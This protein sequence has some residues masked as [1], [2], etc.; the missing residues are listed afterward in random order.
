MYPK[1]S[2]VKKHRPRFI[3]DADVRQDSLNVTKDEAQ[4]DLDFQQNLS[5][6]NQS[7]RLSSLSDNYFHIRQDLGG[8][9][10][11]NVS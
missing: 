11:L 9:I 6:E 4:S 5:P 1:E 3:L 8:L 7:S 2:F 10:S